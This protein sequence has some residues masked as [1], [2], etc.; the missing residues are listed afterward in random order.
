MSRYL[1]LALT[2]LALATLVSAC[3]TFKVFRE[4]RQQFNQH[5]AGNSDIHF[6]R[7]ESPQGTL[8]YASAGDS[9]LPA[10]VLIHGTPGSWSDMSA[11]MIEPQLRSRFQVISIDRPGWG[12]STASDGHSPL[13]FSYQA[14]QIGLLLQQLREQNPAGPIIVVGHSLGASLAPRVAA[15]FPQLVDGLLLLSGTY[16]PELGKPRT[17]HR[18]AKWRLVKPLIGEPLRKA[19][20]EM[21]VL[22]K[23]LTEMNGR[24][25]QLNIPTTMIHGH[26]DFLVSKKNIPFI[27]KVQAHNPNLTVIELKKSGHFT[28]LQQQPL[29]VDSAV[30]LLAKVQQ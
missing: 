13:A 16:N 11:L 9:Q 30:E 20:R 24:W 23:H 25:E 15:D 26:K 5:I 10:L 18:V 28:H 19:N 1:L 6:D 12:Q 22:E 7:I 14:S 29:I 8:H 3:S 21:L 17:H 2:L 27:R 4:H